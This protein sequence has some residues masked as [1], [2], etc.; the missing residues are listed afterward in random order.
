MKARKYENVEFV[1]NH[2][3]DDVKLSLIWKKGGLYLSLSGLFLTDGNTWYELPVRELENISVI[4]DSPLK[5]RI[6]I[7]SLDIMISGKRAEK[8]LFEH[9]VF[10][11]SG[12]YVSRRFG[13]KF[14]RVSFSV[15]KQ[16]VERFAEAFP[17]VIGELR[18]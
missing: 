3:T 14:I 5:L 1:I 18:D 2:S 13:D 9:N 17:G 6:K 16:G 7:P 10:V 15:P 4:S 11:R 12:K 8:L